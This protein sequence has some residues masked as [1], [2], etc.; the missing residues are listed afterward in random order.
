[1]IRYSYRRY[2]MWHKLF[3]C[4]LNYLYTHTS[5]GCENWVV[6]L[7][8]ATNLSFS[9]NKTG[10]SVRLYVNTTEH[11]YYLSLYCIHNLRCYTFALFSVF[12]SL[13]GNVLFEALQ[14]FLHV[15][16]PL[17]SKQH[18]VW[19][20]STLLFTVS[21]HAQITRCCFAPQRPC[22]KFIGPES[23]HLTRKTWLT[24]LVP[25]PISSGSR[26]KLTFP[27]SRLYLNSEHQ[28]LMVP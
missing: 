12:L 7:C 13:Y 6:V 2:E 18:T 1:M 21:H 22:M 4:H 25:F 15:T 8:C 24:D 10:N 11:F 19:I 17:L 9:W 14:Y 27:A 28:R 23:R 20:Y 26:V 5:V 3:G 16:C